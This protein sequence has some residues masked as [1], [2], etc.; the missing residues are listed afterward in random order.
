MKNWLFA[1]MEALYNAICYKF[2]EIKPNV[3]YFFTCV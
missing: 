1:I 2:E 3:I